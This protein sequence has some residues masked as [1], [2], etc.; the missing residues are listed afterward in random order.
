MART[1][2]NAPKVAKTAAA[3][4]VATKPVSI[5]ARRPPHLTPSSWL[6]RLLL[7]RCF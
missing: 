7:L 5:A 3:K 4:R 6:T 2:E 1:S